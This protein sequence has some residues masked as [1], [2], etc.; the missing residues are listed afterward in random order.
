[1]KENERNYTL[2]FLIPAGPTGATG[3]KGIEGPTGPTGPA[4]L[5][6][7][8]FTEFSSRNKNGDLEILKNIILP[9]NS[10][11]FIP[12]ANEIDIDEIGNYEFT[13]SGIIEGL[14]KGE[15]VS[16]SMTVTNAQNLSYNVMLASIV[17]NAAQEYFSQTMLITFQEK[18]NI[19]LLFRKNDSYTA[20]RVETVTL[21]IKKLSFS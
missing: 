20:S 15:V 10:N 6:S 7:L 4:S 21:L 12:K 11:V 1:M 16:I 9:T 18:Q 8:I 13:V 2:D 19:K 14:T 3:P 5:S 17:A